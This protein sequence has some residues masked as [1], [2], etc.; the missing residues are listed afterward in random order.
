[1]PETHITE[2]VRDYSCAVMAA[3]FPD[4]DGV[5][6]LLLAMTD[7]V[8]DEECRALG[9]AACARHDATADGA[10]AIGGARC[11][12]RIQAL[13]NALGYSGGQPRHREP[14]QPTSFRIV[15]H[16]YVEVVAEYEVKAAS[17]PEALQAASAHLCANANTLAWE[18]GDGVDREAVC[19]VIDARGGIV[20]EA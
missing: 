4:N 17:V 8:S 7:A 3:D 5:P 16:R 10:S 9:L 14:V 13:A 2:M 11:E 20:W 18:P 6:P 15:A 12:P 1:M 19:T